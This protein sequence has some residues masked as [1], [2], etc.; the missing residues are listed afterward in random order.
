MSRV[1]VICARRY[2]GHELWTLLGGLQSRGHSFEVVSTALHIAD[3]KTFQPNVLERTVYDVSVDEI[4]QFGGVCVVS[5]NPSDT[6]A[7]WTDTHVLCLLW[8][9]KQLNKVLGAICVSVPTL[10]PVCKGVRVSYFPLIRS[11]KWLETYGA[12]P[13][14]VSLTVDQQVVTAENQMMSEMWAQEISN[15]LEGK[16]PQ[17]S[18]KE[19]DFEFGTFKRRFPAGVDEVIHAAHD[20]KEGNDEH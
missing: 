14:K 11:R 19:T 15:L 18:F 7:Y 20:R 16:E 9:A 2:N 6:E 13:Q 1:L 17:Y 3:E 5:G 8:E 4:H 10:G 12:I